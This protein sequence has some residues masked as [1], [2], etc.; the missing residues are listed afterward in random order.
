MLPGA[1]EDGEM[2]WWLAEEVGTVEWYSHAEKESLTVFVDVLHR[3]S[4]CSL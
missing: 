2:N 3:I 1:D 4:L